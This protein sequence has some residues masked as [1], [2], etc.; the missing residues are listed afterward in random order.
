MGKKHKHPEHVNHERWLV[1]YAD[2]ITLLFA[3][4]VILYALSEVDKNKLKKFAKSVQF[5]FA[6]VGSGGTQ[7]PGNNPAQKKPNLIGDKY[8]PGRKQSEP[9]PYESLA[10]VVQYLDKSITQHFQKDEKDSVELKD[11]GRAIIVRMPVERL[12][13][14]SGATL[15]A[16]RQSFLEG[17]G[18]VIEKYNLLFAVTIEIDHA[19]ADYEIDQQALGAR[20]TSALVSAIWSAHEADARARI[21]T[22]VRVNERT[23]VRTSEA[24]QGRSVVEFRVTRDGN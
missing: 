9:G 22:S 14:P 7:S 10:A 20:R 11:D 13:A 5:A 19:F 8:P 1:S 17:L 21:V 4:F 16:D 15:R 3:F 12:F 2:F 6:H 23:E 24:E 18:D